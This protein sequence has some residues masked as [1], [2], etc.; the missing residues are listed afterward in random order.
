MVSSQETKLSTHCSRSRRGA[1]SPDA[2]IG[3]ICKVP[4]HR[5]VSND[6]E[7]KKGGSL[8]QGTALPSH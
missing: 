5:R 6:L 7:I 1:P 2:P 3:E 4:R 8:I